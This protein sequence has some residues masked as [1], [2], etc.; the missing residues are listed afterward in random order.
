MLY[1]FYFVHCLCA[2]VLAAF[3]ISYWHLLFYQLVGRM[4]F[5]VWAF[6][7]YV[8]PVLTCT[9]SMREALAAFAM[10]YSC[11]CVETKISLTYC[12]Y[13]YICYC[14]V[15]AML[16]QVCG[17]VVLHCCYA[18]VM[19]LLLLCC[20]CAVAMRL[21]CCCLSLNVFSFYALAFHGIG[22][23]KIVYGWGLFRGTSISLVHVWLKSIS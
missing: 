20:C 13:I 16:M 19:R 2:A 6:G 17:C 5:G 22:F 23:A 12:I 9:L 1:L 4:S 3:A 8:V 11:D 18:V 10:S 7:T 15:A 14:S 21:C